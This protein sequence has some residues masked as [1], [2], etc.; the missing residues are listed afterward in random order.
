MGRQGLVR[1]IS[2]VVF[3]CSWLQFGQAQAENEDLA[4]GIRLYDALEYEPAQVLL[5]KALNTEGT[6]RKDIAKAALYL[7]VV[8][9]ALGDQEA[10]S[11]WFTVA[12]SYDD[13]VK[14]PEGTSPKI[15]ELFDELA[16]RLTFARPVMQSVTPEPK[17]TNVPKTPGFDA[18]DK[19]ATADSEPDESSSMLWTYAAG[20]T[21]AVAAGLAIT[22]GVLAFGTAS[23][24][25]SSPHERAELEDLQDTLDR[26]GDLA[27][28]FLVATGV[29]AA[30]TAVVYLVQRPKKRSVESPAISVSGTAKGAMIGTWFSF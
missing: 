19:P 25:E 3:L 22:F 27:N 23:D 9:V 28:S 26:Q 17:L 13:T 7:G 18:L 24:I 2:F 6:S 12:L 14:I 15:S 11:T 5:E 16:G 29:L 30:T 1:K 20:G 10:G 8:R 21:T 4:E